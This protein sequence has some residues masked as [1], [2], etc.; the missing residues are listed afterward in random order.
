MK[1]LKLSILTLSLVVVGAVCTPQKAFADSLNV[2]TSN[3]VLYTVKITT[4]AYSNGEWLEYIYS[5]SIILSQGLLDALK[6]V[7]TNPYD[8]LLPSVANE[9]AAALFSYISNG[10]HIT[11]EQKNSTDWTNFL[12]VIN[13]IVP[14]TNAQLSVFD[15]TVGDFVDIDQNQDVINK[16][17][18]ETVSHSFLTASSST[19]EYKYIDGILTPV[20]YQNFHYDNVDIKSVT[21]R[22]KVS[23]QLYTVSFAGEGV[24]IDSQE[25]LKDE[26]AT[27]PADPIRA[28][29]NF[30]GWFTDNGTFLNEWNFETDAVTQDTTL[31]A[32]WTE[33]VGI[34]EIENASIKIYPN[35]AND[36]LNFSL[37][38]S[39]EIID[40]QGKAVLKSDM[41]VKSVN[42]SSLPS[43]I[44]FL[45][46]MQGKAEIKSFKIIK[47]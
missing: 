2:T 6:G 16:N 36:I 32:K 18:I 9:N 24:N 40:L 27:K 21:L 1:T 17:Y 31:Y 30:D 19:T 22:K 39:F 44:Y 5:P 34:T 46:I 11:A 8:A 42:I 20:T 41:V 15:K 29:Y 10:V 13:N 45:K 23:G 14:G 4:T 28:D 38:T 12:Y 7:L 33:T 47:K 26:F 43:D 3:S 35:P 37:E 25:V